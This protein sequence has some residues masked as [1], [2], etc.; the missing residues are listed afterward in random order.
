MPGPYHT[1]SLPLSGDRI[2]RIVA[3]LLRSAGCPPGRVAAARQIAKKVFNDQLFRGLRRLIFPAVQKRLPVRTG[4]MSRS[5]R[6]VRKG[7]VAVFQV[8]FYGQQRVVR[9]NRVTVRRAVI[10]E[11]TRRGKPLIEQALQASLDAS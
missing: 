7:D 4:R 11:F 1:I 9:P 8:V 5:F 10:E 6:L 2:G 3:G